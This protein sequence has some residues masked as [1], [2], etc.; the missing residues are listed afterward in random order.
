MKRPAGAGLRLLTLPRLLLDLSCRFP[1]FRKRAH[2][3]PTT[4][5]QE[6]GQFRIT[7]H[8]KNCAHGYS[9]IL[10]DGLDFDV[11]HS[12]GLVPIAKAACHYGNRGG[13]KYQD[14]PKIRIPIHQKTNGPNYGIDPVFVPR[15][16][17]LR[18]FLYVNKLAQ[19]RQRVECIRM[20]SRSHCRSLVVM[21]VCRARTE[22]RLAQ[23][24]TCFPRGA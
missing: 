7:E 1:I 3:S 5:P 9:Y 20:Q 24:I 22:R 8:R 16:E 17:Q 6:R 15:V 4:L 23:T 10:M 21:D 11:R 19:R 18:A 13:G 2:D 12:S 14:R